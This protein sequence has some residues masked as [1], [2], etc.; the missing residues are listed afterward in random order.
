MQRV[1]ALFQSSISLFGRL[2]MPKGGYYAVRNGHNPGIYN[3]WPDCQAQV[4]GFSNPVF[5]KFSTQEAAIQ[6]IQGSTTSLSSSSAARP[7]KRSEVCFY[8]AVQKGRK[9]GIYHTW[10]ECQA[11]VNGFPGPIFKKFSDEDDA[12]KFIQ[13]ASAALPQ[14]ESFPLGRNNGSRQQFP[15]TTAADILASRKRSR[16]DTDDVT[17]TSAKRAFQTN[18]SANLAPKKQQ[19]L[20]P[21]AGS[22]TGVSFPDEAGTHVYTD[23]GCFNNG[24]DGAMAGIGVYWSDNHP[25]NVS[26]SLPGRQTNNRAEI[27]A[28]VRAV[29]VAKRRGIDKLVLHTDSQFLINGITKWIKGWKKN[30][31]KLSS[32][33]PVIN[34]EDFEELDKELQGIR[35]K[36]MYVKGHSGDKAND[37]VDL[38]AKQGASKKL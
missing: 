19:K 37:A 5:K 11:Q 29:Q 9:P 7:P 28:A 31:W 32:G 17:S 21:S 23:G 13:S 6:F 10:A 14:T 22:F 16:L 27:H 15:H 38:L 3:S 8:Y 1:L 25:E 35:V 12:N 18:A 36:W 20:D 24:R 2:I 34:R 33:G 26:E 30:G 4:N